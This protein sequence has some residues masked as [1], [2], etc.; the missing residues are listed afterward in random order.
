LGL[1]ILVIFE[2]QTDYRTHFSF[3]TAKFDIHKK[4]AES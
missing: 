3:S 4:T 1:K 2:E